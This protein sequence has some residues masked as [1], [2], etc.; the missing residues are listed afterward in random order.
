MAI[1]ALQEHKTDEK[2]TRVINMLMQEGLTKYK[3]K[4]SKA[5]LP[6]RVE[7]TKADML[8][9]KGAVF[10]VRDKSHFTSVGVKGY[11]ITSKETLIEQANKITH[12]TPNVYRR[13]QYADQDR[14]LIKGFVEENLQQINTFVVD[15]D[16]KKHSVQDI[17]LACLDQSIGQPTLILSSDRGYHIFFAL[18]TPI[19]IS[20][21]KE[22]RSIKVAKR[23]SDNIKRSLQ[24]VDADMYCN[25]FGFFR[26]PNS[27]NIE[28][29][30]ETA[31][32][33]PA[34][35]I[36][37]SQQKD[38]DLGRSLY[39]VP[40]KMHV[41]SLIHSEWFNKL[42]HATDV[43]GEK[44][45]IGRNNVLFTL[46]LVC[47]QDGQENSLTFDL[48]DQ[49]NTNLRYPLTAQDMK[50]IISSAY[51]GRYKGA[52]KEYVEQLLALYVQGAENIPLYFG[53]KVWYKHKKAREDRQR[54][55]YDEWEEDMV[56]Y[57]TAEKS[58]SEP[59]IWRTQKEIC[60][61]V[62]IASSTLNNL[63]KLSTKLLKTTTGK[64]RH[65]KTGWTTVELYI[66]YIIQLKKDS[67]VRFTKY[68]QETV[69]EQIESLEIIGGYHQLINYLEKLRNDKDL[70]VHLLTEVLINN[71]G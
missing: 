25:D 9:K 67:A 51:S 5:A 47:F 18:E 55:H 23:I 62:G 27:Q 65:S 39:I 57:I 26:M 64:G 71:T 12:F 54:S 13:Y 66:A 60:E 52:K 14:R 28:W 32:Y 2:L 20:N 56:K 22:F 49:Y 45:Q 70:N 7:A 69:A 19:F 6:M 3:T 61:T 40:Q 37:W 8:H 53:N 33:H 4:H 29:F 15:I 21:K 30:D 38:D 50:A 43:K 1:F 44:G 48:L 46:A 11:I 63:I 35:L 58:S 31:I 59:F 10:A 41:T 16:T 68:V 17:L 24:S 34:T 42:I 36:K